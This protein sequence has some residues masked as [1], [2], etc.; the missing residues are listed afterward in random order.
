VHPRRRA[1][2]R[3]AGLDYELALAVQLTRRVEESRWHRFTSP[4][5]PRTGECTKTQSGASLVGST[6]RSEHMLP[7]MRGVRSPSAA[8]TTVA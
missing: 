7:R 1:A 3:N 8:N 4:N 5:C 2:L 6:V